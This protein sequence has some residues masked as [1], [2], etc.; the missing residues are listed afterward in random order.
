MMQFGLGIQVRQFV[1]IQMKTALAS[2]L[3]DPQLD[4]Y[5]HRSFS[6]LILILNLMIYIKAKRAGLKLTYI[7]G[8]GVCII[9]EILL[10]IAMYYVDFPWGTQP[11]HLLLAT[12]LFGYQLYWIFRIKI[13]SYEPR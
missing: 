13:R 1:D 5:I 2:W 10:G 7:Y 3:S 12:M 11:L 9:G 8:A 4:F 6:L